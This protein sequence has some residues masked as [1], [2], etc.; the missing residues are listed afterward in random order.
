MCASIY[1]LLTGVR[2]PPSI[3]RQKCDTVQRLQAMGVP[4]SEEQ[5][6][7]IFKGLSIEPQQRYQSVA[8]LYQDLYGEWI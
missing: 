5:D 6:L 8:E 4:I 7:A 2:I 3:E 1:Y